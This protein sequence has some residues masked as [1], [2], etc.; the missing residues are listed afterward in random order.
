MRFYRVKR[1]KS[2]S[3]AYSIQGSGVP[4]FNMSLATFSTL[5][6]GFYLFHILS[7]LNYCVDVLLL[8][9]V[10]FIWEA[11]QSASDSEQQH[12][13]KTVTKWRQRALSCCRKCLQACSNWRCD[14][15]NVNEHTCTHTNKNKRE[16][17]ILDTCESYY[18]I[19]MY[20]ELYVSRNACSSKRESACCHCQATT[21]QD[22]NQVANACLASLMML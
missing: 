1:D 11:R 8:Q 5:L 19:C 20:V 22:S 14:V 18:I 17:C 12:L 4:H 6:N 13:L 16:E 10:Y 9:Y 15:R 2:I 21:I 3:E 7:H